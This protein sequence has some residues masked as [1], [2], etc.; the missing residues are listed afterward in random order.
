MTEQHI[1]LIGAG[2]M[3]ASLAAGVEAAE[4]ATICA[5]ADPAEGAA[6][7]VAEKL[8]DDSI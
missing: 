6:A 4:N 5:V 7:A 3:G 2:K 8:G 1:G